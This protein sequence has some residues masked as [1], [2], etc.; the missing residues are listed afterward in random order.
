MGFIPEETPFQE[1][2]LKTTKP[3]TGLELMWHL[4]TLGYTTSPRFTVMSKKAIDTNV[5]DV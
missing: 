3:T 4:R 1:L 5:T 2:L